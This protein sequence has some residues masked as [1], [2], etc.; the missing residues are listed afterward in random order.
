[1]PRK[2]L[3]Q[4]CRRRVDCVRE[5]MEVKKNVSCMQPGQ[6]SMRKPEKVGMP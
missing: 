3:T 5:S 4:G 1:M 6:K 2:F